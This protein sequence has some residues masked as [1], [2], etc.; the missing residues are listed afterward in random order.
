MYNSIA[1]AVIQFIAGRFSGTTEMTQSEMINTLIGAIITGATLWWS[2]RD[3]KN[4]QQ[5]SSQ[6]NIKLMLVLF[7]VG[8]YSTGCSSYRH[9]RSFDPATGATSELTSFRA[10]WLSKTAIAG[11][12]SRTTESHKTN[13]FNYSRAVGVDTVTNETDVEGINAL[14]ALIGNALLQALKAGAKP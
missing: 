8:F 2:Y 14:N 5:Q 10:P 11:L 3:K 7:F 1:R 4:P 13:S 12:K 6:V 9:T